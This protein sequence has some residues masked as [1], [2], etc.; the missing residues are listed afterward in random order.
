MDSTVTSPATHPQSER[1]SRFKRPLV[2][3]SILCVLLG[4]SY[5]LGY[6]R[7]R[8]A[9]TNL[10]AQL[11]SERRSAQATQLKLS[12][13]LGTA[14]RLSLL[15][16]ARRSVDQAITALEGRNFGVAEQRLKNAAKLLHLGEDSA[17]VKN[18][19]K[20]FETYHFVATEDL[21]TQ[22]RQLVDWVNQL[23]PHVVLTVP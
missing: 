5:L 18:L 14:R 23:D 15:L 6:F 4:T 19:A 21:G 2:F 16:D 8:A 22:R 12:T 9:L 1:R 11:D 7:G 3:A 10:A 13:E 20:A 17:A